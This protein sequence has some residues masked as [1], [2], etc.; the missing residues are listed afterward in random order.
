[1]LTARIKP[2]QFI[3]IKIAVIDNTKIFL[4]DRNI[5]KNSLIFPKKVIIINKNIK[6]HNPRWMA[7]SIAGINFISLKNKGWGRPQN[8]EA[9]EV[10]NIPL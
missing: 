5:K 8:N 1:M 9:K 10:N 6:D 4:L 3:V 2:V 7:T